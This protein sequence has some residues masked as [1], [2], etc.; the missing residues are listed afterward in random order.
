MYLEQTTLQTRIRQQRSKQ[1][2]SQLLGSAVGFGLLAIAFKD[3]ATVTKATPIVPL[4]SALAHAPDLSLLRPPVS[5]DNGADVAPAQ[6]VAGYSKLTIDNG[7]GR[8]AVV[9]LSDL[10]SGDTLRFVYVKARSQVT[11]TNLGTCNCELK[12]ATGVDW[13]S[14]TQQFRKRQKLLA[15]SEPL[16][17]TVEYHD[18]GA[19]WRTYS[20]TLHQVPN[21]TAATKSIDENEF[22]PSEDITLEGA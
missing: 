9:K 1:F 18:T 3:V 5:L 22:G 17:F 11:L 19:Y 7:N 4:V 6:G 12:F 13:D 8:D 2:L 15:F 10:D 21:G 20:V 16:E 14:E